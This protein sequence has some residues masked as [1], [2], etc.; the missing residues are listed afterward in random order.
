MGEDDEIKESQVEATVK[1]YISR[2]EKFSFRMA[3]SLGTFRKGVE[4]KFRFSSFLL[5]IAL[6]VHA[7]FEGIALGLAQDNASLVNFIL[8]IVFHKIATTLTLGMSLMRH[9]VEHETL[10]TFII[11][12][13]ALATPVGILIGMFLAPSLLTL[14]TFNCL[15]AGIFIYVSASEVIVEEFA[16]GTHKWWK[17]AAF[18]FGAVVIVS[19]GF[20]NY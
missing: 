11:I 9:C 6:A 15:V 8:A 17:C 1:E 7:V 16:I 4:K 2:N 14:I 18:V 20:I 12:Y 10:A 3:S 13:Y 19:L 5:L